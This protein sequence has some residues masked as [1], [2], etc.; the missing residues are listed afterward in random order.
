MKTCEYVLHFTRHGTIEK[1]EWMVLFKLF[2]S[3]NLNTV[4]LSTLFNNNQQI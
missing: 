3:S 4:N 2:V 1:R